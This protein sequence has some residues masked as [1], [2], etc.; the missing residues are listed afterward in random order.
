MDPTREADLTEFE[1]ISYLARERA[2][3]GQACALYVL[4]LINAVH[5][6]AT[7]RDSSI[8]V[9]IYDEYGLQSNTQIKPLVKLCNDVQLGIEVADENQESTTSFEGQRYH[10]YAV[11]QPRQGTNQGFKLWTLEEVPQ[12]NLNGEFDQY[13]CSRAQFHPASDYGDMD[14]SLIVTVDDGARSPSSVHAVERPYLTNKAVIERV[15]DLVKGKADPQLSEDLMIDRLISRYLPSSR[16]EDLIDRPDG[17]KLRHAKVLQE[18]IEFYRK[19]GAEPDPIE[20]ENYLLTINT[21]TG[22][23][24]VDAIFRDLGSQP[25]YGRVG[26]LM[27]DADEVSLAFYSDLSSK[28]DEALDSSGIDFSEIFGLPEIVNASDKL[29]KQINDLLEYYANATPSE[30]QQKPKVDNE[31]TKLI[32][33]YRVK[34]EIPRNVYLDIGSIDVRNIA[35]SV[36]FQQGDR[37]YGESGSGMTDFS[38]LACIVKVYANDEQTVFRDYNYDHSKKH[39]FGCEVEGALSAFEGIKGSRL[40]AVDCKEAFTNAESVENYAYKCEKAFHRGEATSSI[41]SHCRLAFADIE[42]CSG[43]IASYCVQAFTAT[44]AGDF[45]RTGVEWRNNTSEFCQESFVRQARGFSDRDTVTQCRA[46]LTRSQRKKYH[47]T[48]RLTDS[49]SMI[50]NIEIIRRESTLPLPVWEPLRDDENSHKPVSGVRLLPEARVKRRKDR[51]TTFGFLTLFGYSHLLAGVDSADVTV[52]SLVPYVDAPVIGDFPLPLMPIE[53]I[54]DIS[55]NT[56]HRAQGYEKPTDAALVQES[57]TDVP[58]IEDYDVSDVPDASYATFDG[59]EPKKELLKNGLYKVD[60]KSFVPGSAIN[61]PSQDNVLNSGPTFEVEVD[62]KSGD[63]V[64]VFATDSVVAE[65][66]TVRLTTDG[67]KVIVSTKDGEPFGSVLSE[68]YFYTEKSN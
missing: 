24:D 42:K 11:H 6:K 60:F 28:P 64:S 26:R 62:S 67:S 57:A 65:R 29:L 2:A 59:N 52:N 36:I 51:I 56:D 38:D 3:G 12:D 18:R 15:R 66:I 37:R 49:M 19:H 43:S 48:H 20:L 16:I 63:Q 53:V 41:A 4:Q 9:E 61:Y 31:L 10:L 39:L 21:A 32:R 40:V 1:K 47:G 23:I 5:E 55:N 17:R 46:I 22:Y 7:R 45:H 25:R 14:W 54:N 8:P 35:Q 30:L 68:L 44:Y 33:E 13:E 58:L 50:P 34:N 27:P